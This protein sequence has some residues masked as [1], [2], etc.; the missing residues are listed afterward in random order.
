MKTWQFLWRLFLFNKWTLALQV[1]AAIVAM[2]AIEHT[3]ALAQREVFD[4]LTNDARTSLEVWA[5]CAVLVALAV[6]YSVTW[7]LDE[8]L[9]RFNRFT[10]AA[11]LQRNAFDYVMDLQ[12]DRPLPA[13]P[14]EAV[15]RFRGD[16]NEPM[17]YMLEFDILAAQFLFFVIAIF[18]M[19][20]ISAVT[21][22]AAFLPL[23][24]VTAIVH[25]ARRRIQR[26]REAAREA[27]GG[28]TGFIGETFGMVETIKVSNAES[29][30]IEQFD[31]VNEERGRTSLRDEVLAKVLNAFSHNAHHVATGLM[32]VLLARSMSQGTITVGDLSL[33]VFYLAQTQALSAAIGELLTGYRRVGVSVDRRSR[34]V[35]WCKSTSSC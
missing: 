4:N 3:V 22:F 1:G 13:S 5:L 20:Q 31:R 21:A 7:I 27:A 6:G 16:A 26:Y 12:G 18:I 11:L 17:V 24:A 28:V 32:L 14:G 35:K 9:F 23:L 25:T 10:L 34:P 19:V 33:F 8:I 29:R 15:S 2:V 30:V